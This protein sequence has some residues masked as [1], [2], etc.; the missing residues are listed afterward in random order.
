MISYEDY[1]RLLPKAEL[2]CHFAG[3]IRA[4]RLVELAAKHDIELPTTDPEQLYVYDNIFD[5]LAVYG[6][7]HDVLIEREDFAVVAYDGIADAVAQGNLRYR[8]LFVN[9]DSFM[10]AGV[11]YATVIDGM[12]DGL[13]RAQ[14]EFGVGFGIVPSINR[15]AAIELSMAMVQAM[16]DEPRPAVVG[17]GMDDL[18][19]DGLEA[20]ERWLELYELAS[21]HGL[22]RSAHVGEING[23]PAANIAY[24]LDVLGCDRIDHGYHVLDDPDLLARVVAD[25]VQFT[26]APHSTCAVYGFELATHPIKQMI[27]E[28]VRLTLNSDDPPMFHTDIGL[29]YSETL[30]AMAFGPD[31]A[32]RLSLQAIEAAWCDEEAKQS[33]TRDFV[34]Q[35]AALDA[36]LDPSSVP[37]VVNAS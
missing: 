22:R 19:A 26:C 24:A 9:V 12:I 13:T 32:K 30:A 21:R 4:T 14:H 6:V 34:A 7:V 10:A 18:P 3:T 31:V 36:V 35:F 25:E 27:N 2:H 37:P 17:L 11:A 29:E 5:F 15:S 8:E 33:L 23:A 16:I 20:P 28:G 1:L